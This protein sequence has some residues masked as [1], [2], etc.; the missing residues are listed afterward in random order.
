MIKFKDALISKELLPAHETIARHA[1][2]GLYCPVHKCINVLTHQNTKPIFDRITVGTSYDNELA[3]LYWADSKKSS[4]D[5]RRQLR[6]EFADENKGDWLW[7]NILEI[8]EII[9]REINEFGADLI[10]HDQYMDQLRSTLEK[11][12]A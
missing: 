11:Q 12:A 3:F 1:V 9:D 6:A 5:L 8:Q 7:T 10:T 2:L 4:Q